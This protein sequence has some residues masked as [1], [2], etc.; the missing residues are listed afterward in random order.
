MFKKEKLK[1]RAKNM[2]KGECKE[3]TMAA[4]NLR[5]TLCNT[6]LTQRNVCRNNLS[7][8]SIVETGQEDPR[9][10]GETRVPDK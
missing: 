5:G 10:N 8:E 9:P 1:A 7:R 2:M 6:R 3:D 4:H